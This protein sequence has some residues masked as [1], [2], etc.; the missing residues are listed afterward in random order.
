M[1]SSLLSSIYAMSLAFINELKEKLPY[2]ISYYIWYA[3]ITG[4]FFPIT[5]LSGIHKTLPRN[6]YFST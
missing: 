1:E 2:K 4:G 5:A 3:S 6:L